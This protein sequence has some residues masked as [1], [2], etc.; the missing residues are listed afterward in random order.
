MKI[1]SIV[2][3][4]FMTLNILMAFGYFALLL[5]HKINE[6][7]CLPMSFRNQ[8]KMH[9]SVLSLFVAVALAQ[10][11]LTGVQ[12]FGPAIKIW[13]AESRSAWDSQYL[14]HEAVVPSSFRLASIGAIR[15]NFLTYSGMYTLLGG[16]AL[17]LLAWTF[18]ELIK[19]LYC[20]RR[21]E[22][23]L[24]TL[25]AIGS[26]KIFVSATHQVPFSFWRPGLKAVVVPLAL[27]SEAS[28]LRAIVAHELQHHRQF[29]TRWVY[30][31]LILKKLG[32]LNPAF[33]KWHQW[34]AEL[35]E[36][37]CDEAVIGRRAA[38]S[39]Q[40]IGCLLEV[41]ASTIKAREKSLCAA[42]IPLITDSHLLKRRIHTM[43]SQRHHYVFGLRHKIAAFSVTI[44]TTLTAIA[45][46]SMI[47][48][49]ERRFTMEDVQK[50]AKNDLDK[51]DFPLTINQ[52]VL[53]QI[54]RYAATPDGRLFV[55]LSLQR[56]NEYTSLIQES[57][58][59]Y[60]IPEELAAIPIVESGYQNLPPS[61]TPGFGAG[62]W[63]F[64]APTARSFGLQV[65]ATIDQRMNPKALTDA[66]MRYLK[67]GFAQFGDWQLA[68][69]GYNAG[70]GAVQRAMEA[71]NSNDAWTLS[72]AGI[73]SDKHYLAKVMAAVFIMKHPEI[74][75]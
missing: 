31:H 48:A 66:A 45:V 70:N 36:F 41:A 17:V 5:W 49:E 14:N 32:L 1:L 71:H 8:L 16:L 39:L 11:F 65:D 38:S 35:Q 47:H 22:E 42:G 30:L 18:G 26:V 61:L 52:D 3:E 2:A 23:S 27:L 63:M 72:H 74:L 46:A 25:K 44:V 53:D 50:L 28:Q 58:K 40:Y 60:Q 59:K 13:V 75:D 21:I 7:Y 55:K 19:S 54:N 56:M 34:I 51:K 57:L 29:D 43:L 9:N 4:L 62:I 37:A 69:L 67:G 20:L 33:R 12:P 64:L 24:V 10:P 15:G 6:K 68:I 73:E